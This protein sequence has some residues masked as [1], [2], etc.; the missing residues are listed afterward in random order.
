MQK[1][2]RWQ[3]QK[4]FSGARESTPKQAVTTSCD[5]REK[6]NSANVTV[7]PIKQLT[8][9]MFTNRQTLWAKGR[10]ACA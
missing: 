10:A 3:R 1:L 5:Y 8:K 6:I 2:P 9:T 7:L 4:P